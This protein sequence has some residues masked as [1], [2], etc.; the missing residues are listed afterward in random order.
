MKRKRL[1]QLRK[2]YNEAINSHLDDQEQLELLDGVDALLTRADANAARAGD[3]NAAAI[4]DCKRI[5]DLRAAI[6]RGIKCADQVRELNKRRHPC[7]A[8][9]DVL[10]M[11]L[12]AALEVDSRPADDQVDDDDPEIPICHICRTRRRSDDTALIKLMDLCVRCGQVF[13]EE[14]Q[15][16]RAICQACGGRKNVG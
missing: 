16:E 1:E 9:L 2:I 12:C 15:A 8:T 10:H 14:C 13:C 4:L 11:D 6:E 5:T 3:L 7:V